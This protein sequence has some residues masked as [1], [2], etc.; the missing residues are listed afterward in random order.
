[1]LKSRMYESKSH[2]LRLSSCFVQGSKMKF[3]GKNAARGKIRRQL[4]R[5]GES[6]LHRH[7]DVLLHVQLAPMQNTRLLRT[8]T[9]TD[10]R[11]RPN[12]GD[13]H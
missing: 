13:I 5:P 1:M 3:K 9:D 11:A 6:K 2:L 7:L 10:H 4:R 8:L 12:V